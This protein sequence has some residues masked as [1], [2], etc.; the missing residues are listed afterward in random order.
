M[1]K[2]LLITLIVILGITTVKSQD[3]TSATGYLGF[4][5]EKQKIIAENMWAYVKANAHT[6][7]E[8]KVERKKSDLIAT[9]DRAGSEIRLM[10]AFQGEVTLRDSMVKYLETSKK[11]LNGEFAEIELLEANANTSY[12]LMKI[13]L[14]KVSDANEKYAIKNEM[15]SDQINKF[16]EEHNIELIKSSSE[17]TA[18]LKISNIVYK[19]YNSIYLIYFR[20]YIE[21]SFIIDAINSG[22]TTAIK[23]RMDSLIIAYKYGEVDLKAI[24]GY[25][26]DYSLKFACQKALSHYQKVATILL[27]KI[28]DYYK[29]E[30]EL[31]A[32]KKRF[33]A[34]PE[35]KRTQQDV[36]AYNFAI[37][38]YNN[39]IKIYNET[40]KTLNTEIQNNS[41]Q[42]NNAVDKFIDKNIPK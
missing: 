38:K 16:A 15:I 10:P 31:N 2:I 32:E 36:D 42:W 35:K 37:T 12:E 18:N 27:P 23:Q 19:Y 6:N 20:G 9:I 28:L 13:Y 14:Q 4:I 40:I 11:M 7:S 24:A 26:G 3:F 25:N 17:L 5:I 39:S 41:E 1:K 30:N 21:D 22:D 8:K 29:A 33:E 34:I